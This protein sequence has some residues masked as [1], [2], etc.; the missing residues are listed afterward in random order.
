MTTPRDQAR[1]V[2]AVERVADAVEQVAGIVATTCATCWPD[3]A[4]WKS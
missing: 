2:A 1:I 4:T 3:P